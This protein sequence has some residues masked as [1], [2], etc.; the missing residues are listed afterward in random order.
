VYN[1]LFGL[2]VVG[3]G[4]LH[5]DRVV[6]VAQLREAEAAHVREVVHLVHE[7]AVAVGVQG[8]Q[9]A[10]E[11]VELDSELS[12]QGAIHIGEHLVGCQEVLRVV[13]EII[14]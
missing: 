8:D 1:K 9:G 6:A 13:L 10:T 12:G 7:G 14:D 4:G 3:G 2:L 11:Q 5:L